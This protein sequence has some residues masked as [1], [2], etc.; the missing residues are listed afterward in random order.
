MGEWVYGSL[1]T[2]NANPCIVTAD[3][4]DDQNE[5]HLGIEY[6]DPET[7]GQFTGLYDVNRYP[8]YEGDQLYNNAGKRYQHSTVFFRDGMFRVVH[9]RGDYPLKKCF[10]EQ[11][12]LEVVE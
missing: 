8:I 10:I 9:D 5:M 11:Y 4:S 6:V 3:V 2:T 7:V 12:K 1:I